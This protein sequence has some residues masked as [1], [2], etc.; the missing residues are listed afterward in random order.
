M[1]ATNTAPELLIVDDALFDEHHSRGYHP[2]RP[3]RLHAARTALDRCAAEGLP[4]RRITARDA[5]DEELARVHDAGYLETL[6]GLAGNFAALDPD[7]YL[8]PSSVAAARRAAGAAVALVDALLDPKSARNN[9]A[10][11]PG[12]ALLRPPGHHA[13][14]AKGMGFCLLNNVAVAAASALAK[15]LSR[16]A[17][18]DWDV[19]HGN[20]TQDIFWDD[21]RVLYVSL[22]QYPYYPGTGGLREM[23]GRDAL[24]H[25][26]NVPLSTGAGDAV[27]GEAFRQ[28]VDPLL[29]AFAPELVLVSAGF[30]AHQRDPLADMCV[31]DDGFASMSTVLTRAALRHAGGKI[32]FFLEGGYDLTA[33]QTSLAETLLASANAASS[34]PPARSTA[35]VSFRHEDEVTRARKVAAEN[36][37]G[38]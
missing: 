9:A 8:A 35:P 7:T 17:I 10:P 28:I 32:A 6:A 27:Y 18:I 15:G 37:R 21:P 30:D 13:T 16:V 24:G 19:H 38:L 23:G 4:S 2:E 31:T 12:L 5:S 1:T 14:R 29:D 33:L 11:P 3:E 20:G 22:H 34:E 25:T 36:W 26:V